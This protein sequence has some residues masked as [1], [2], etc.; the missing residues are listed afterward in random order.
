MQT[1]ADKARPVREVERLT[2][3]QLK[4]A[5]FSHFS[6][7]W[8][9]AAVAWGATNKVKPLAPLVILQLG[10]VTRAT[11][12]ITQMVNGIVFSAYPSEAPLQIDLYT[13]GNTVSTPEGSYAE[14]TAV[15][16]LLD[17]VNYL[18]STATIE[19]SNQNNVGVSLMG[20]VQDLSEVIN[21]SR[22][23]YR[24]MSEIRLTFTQWAAEYNGVLNESS[25]IFN[26]NGVPIGVNNANW[27]PTASGGGTEELARVK[28]GAFEET[29]INQI[30]EEYTNG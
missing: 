29:P 18:D 28:S 19:W 26:K 22:W 12:P 4:Q 7:Y 10:T 21:D 16:D 23:Q 30:Q 14:N 15:S 25:I 6:A 5:I 20:G 8:G 3:N 11:Q 27:Q 9:G 24:A 2:L 17:F 1:K 13:K